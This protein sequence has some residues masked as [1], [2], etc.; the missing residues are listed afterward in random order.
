MKTALFILFFLSSSVLYAGNVALSEKTSVP[1][2]ERIANYL[3]AVIFS[4]SQIVGDRSGGDMFSGHEDQRFSFNYD[5]EQ[6][7][8]DVY[9]VG[10][11]ESVSDIEKRLDFTQKLILGLN[12]K[13]KKYY[14]VELGVNDLEIDYFN[15]KYGQEVVKYKDGKY[16]DKSKQMTLEPTPVEPLKMQNP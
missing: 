7:V 9:V 6:Q 4:A 1:V 14:G 8:I 13:I 12:Q 15:R 10:N 3:Q 5:P 11:L 16:I 2:G